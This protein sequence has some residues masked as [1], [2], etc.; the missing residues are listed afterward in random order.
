M[1]S[2]VALATTERRAATAAGVGVAILDGVHEPSAFEPARFDRLDGAGG[3]VTGAPAPPFNGTRALSAA[4]PEPPRRCLDRTV[5]SR[6]SEAV[7]SA[8]ADS[9][10]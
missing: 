10:R 3:L 6:L 4:R 9:V 7:W 5:H 1:S 2:V 8:S